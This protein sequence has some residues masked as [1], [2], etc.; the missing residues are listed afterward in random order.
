[1]EHMLIKIQD[2]VKLVVQVNILQIL[3]LINVLRFVKHKIYML[4]L[5]LEICVYNNVIKM[6]QL[7]LEILRQ[8]LV[9]INVLLIKSYMPIQ[10]LNHVF[11]TVHLV[12]MHM[13]MSIPTK[14]VKLDALAFYSL[15][16]P[17]DMENA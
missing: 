10:L 14:H 12:L 2:I 11:I 15:T 5:I 3:V 6:E 16:I 7:F 13:I 1:M 4:M 9:L 8:K 17:Q